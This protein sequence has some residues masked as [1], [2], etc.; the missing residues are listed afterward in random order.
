MTLPGPR[1][2]AARPHRLLDDL[3]ILVRTAWQLD[4]G[5][6]V[7]Q[8]VSLVLNGLLSGVGLFLLVP[9]VATVT[10]P[11][12]VIDVP[13]VG[14]LGLGEAPLWTL[15]AGFIGLTALQAIVARTATVN[16][17]RLQQR[18]VDRLRHDAFAAVLAA[19]WSFVMQMRRSDV[20]H[21]ITGGASRAGMAVSLLIS[22]AVALV[23][24]ISTTIVALYVAP[25]VALLAL[26]AILVLSMIQGAGIR[27]AHRMGAQ[28]S[29]RG[30]HLQGVVVDSLDSLRLVRAH[31]ASDVWVDRLADAFT[32]TRDVQ[33]ANTER[34]S[35]IAAITTVV[36]AA[37]ASTMVLVATWA[38]VEP[39]S[40]VVMVLL[41]ARLASQAQTVVRTT[42][43]LANA[44]PAVSDV[45][46]LT[47]EARA[48]VELPLDARRSLLDDLDL[49]ASDSNSALISL[50]DVTFHYADSDN[51]VTDLSFD[52]RRGSITALAGRSGA[53][54]STTA[55]LVIGLLQPQRGEVLVD[56][57]AVD[58]ADLPHWRRHVAYVPQETVLIPG[59]LRDNL[60]WSAGRP[61]TD[62]DCWAALDQAAAAFAQSLP[63]GLDTMLGERGLRL[64]GGERQRVAI[65]RALLRRPALLVLDEATSSLDDETESAVLQTVVSLAPSI[66]VLMIA[67]RR[68]TLDVAHQVIRLEHGRTR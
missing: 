29:E 65:A 57:H 21:V 54:K 31:D 49:S 9:I 5:R 50:R 47:R 64:S 60:V 48:A 56:G 2:T 36:T 35:T 25:G 18:L 1:S 22:G 43:Q 42:T 33:L 58:A 12:G 59:T 11:G 55:D 23:L 45:T 44:L 19:R 27:P 38:D 37:A 28:L 8:S 61:V 52:I 62:D 16:S 53:G 20:I 40:I 15:L 6:V 10:D 30:R 7:V 24:A 39:A 3:S 51:G 66:T 32:T 26:A 46:E 63:E 34:M 17:A 14:R 67:H 68:S 13:V 4:R 41:L